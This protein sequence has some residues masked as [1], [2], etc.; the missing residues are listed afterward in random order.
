MG[1]K[2]GKETPFAGSVFPLHHG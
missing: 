1:V 2:A